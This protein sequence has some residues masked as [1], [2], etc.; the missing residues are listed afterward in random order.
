MSVPLTER[1]V[2]QARATAEFLAQHLAGR[3]P[4]K[5]WWSPYRRTR[6]TAAAIAS[7]LGPDIA[8]AE[9]L[10]ISETQLGL[11]QDTVDFDAKYPEEQRHY[12]LHRN[13]QDRFF[14]RPPLGESMYDVCLRLD[15]FLK[16][17]LCNE[18]LNSTHVVVTHGYC[19]G[20]LA[21]MHQSWPYERFEFINPRNASVHLLTSTEYRELFTPSTP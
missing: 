15:L 21:M 5:L 7:A 11:A 20:G 2:A 8:Q 10:Y 13:H 17:K 6:D 9:S 12:D 18:P 3:S 4:V 1:G 16:L 14:A 19:V